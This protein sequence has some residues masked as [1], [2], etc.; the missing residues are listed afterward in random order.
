MN[1]KYKELIPKR[2]NQ[3]RKEKGISEYQLS[4]NLGHCKGYIQSITSGRALPSMEAFLE[5]CN[6][7]NITPS[8]FLDPAIEDN[9]LYNQLIYQIKLLSHDDLVLLS[10]IINRLVLDSPKNP[11]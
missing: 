5:I 9:T 8:E 6:Y 3:L 11:S 2:I 10:S 1:N 4:I 7:F